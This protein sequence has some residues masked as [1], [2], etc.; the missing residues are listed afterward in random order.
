M[1]RRIRAR[2]TILEQL[3]R[4]LLACG[5]T[6][7]RQQR[8]SQLVLRPS[9]RHTHLRILTPVVPCAAELVLSVR[10]ESRSAVA[11]T[12]RG[13]T[14][15]ISARPSWWARRRTVAASAFVVFRRP[16]GQLERFHG[17]HYAPY[18]RRVVPTLVVPPYGVSG[19]VVFTVDMPMAKGQRTFGPGHRLRVRLVVAGVSRRGHVLDMRM[20]PALAPGDVVS[21]DAVGRPCVTKARE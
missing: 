15:T 10:V 2:V 21:Y 8:A 11:I 13:L 3:L 6:L 7:V 18:G 4:D 5:L 14:A 1:R 16:G 20:P 19:Y 12:V 9:W 17:P